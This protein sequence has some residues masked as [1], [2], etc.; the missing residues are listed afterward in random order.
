MAELA[1]T[2]LRRRQGRRVRPALVSSGSALSCGEVW[3]VRPALASAAGPDELRLCPRRVR[4]SSTPSPA[5][6]SELCS[7][8]VKGTP[9]LPLPNSSPRPVLV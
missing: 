5:C 4:P 2:C 9:S 8:P 6:A 3:Q 7:Q 1:C